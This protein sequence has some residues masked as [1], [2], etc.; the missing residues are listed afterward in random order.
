MEVELT[1]LRRVWNKLGR[2]DPLWAVLTD[3]RFKGGKWIPD[4]FFATGLAEVEDLLRRAEA[5]DL[6]PSRG[7]A[8]DFGC[9]VGR[10][11]QALAVQ[12]DSVV[13]VDI[14]ESMVVQA[15]RYNSHG[16]KCRFIVNERSDLTR[17][18]DAS[19]DF[20]LSRLVLQHMEPRYGRAYVTEFLRVLKPGGIA[21]FEV[22][23]MTHADLPPS[24]RGLAMVEGAYRAELSSDVSNLTVPAGAVETIRVTLRNP[25]T[26]PW[27]RSTCG[28]G[29]GVGNH[30]Y[31]ADGTMEQPD[32][33]RTYLPHEVEGGQRVVLDLPV[34]VPAQ[35]GSYVLELDMVHEGVTWFAHRGSAT[36]RIPVRVYRS[37]GI[38]GR[39]NGRR[40]A[41]EP[42][43]VIEMHVIPEAEVI[44]VVVSAGGRVAGIDRHE[45]PQMTDC[46]YF[47]TKV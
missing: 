44:E 37:R 15:E 40:H 30:W 25:G 45:V 33:G 20:V 7:S 8:M 14:A 3:A 46:T 16:D 43:A 19:F 32:D 2:D 27:A 38:R 12:F 41:P 5:Y 35:P 10:L 36:L 4:E 34:T 26:N 22:P 24:L 13:G 47:V 18:T 9:G 29:I 28:F 42:A 17:F 1:E 39:R 23:S 6:K 31:R 11:S 21:V